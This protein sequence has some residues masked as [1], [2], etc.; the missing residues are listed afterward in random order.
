MTAPLTRVWRESLASPMLVVT[1]ASPSGLTDL[2]VAAIVLVHGLT[3]VTHN[4]M[5]FSRVTGLEM[6]RLAGD[7]VRPPLRPAFIDPRVVLELDGL[8]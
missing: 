6:G 2:Q 5:E 8:R 1:R 4:V 3:L 7:A